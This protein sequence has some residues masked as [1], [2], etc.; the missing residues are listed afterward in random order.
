MAR[1]EVQGQG[2]FPH[3]ASRRVLDKNAA[4]SWKSDRRIRP[5]RPPNEPQLSCPECGNTRLYRD[6][7][8]YCSS[9]ADIQRWLC[10]SCNYRFSQHSEKRP[11]RKKQYGYINNACPSISDR[12]VC[13]LLTEESKNL[14][15]SGTRQ[16]KSVGATAVINVKTEFAEQLKRDGY[17]LDTIRQCSYYL[18]LF[19]KK[20]VNILHPEQVKA[21]VAEQK[22]QTH[23]KATA[24]TIYGIFAKYMHLQW[25]PPRYRYDQKIPF[26]P[27]EKEINDLIAGTG[28]KTSMLLRLLK[29]TGARLTEALRIKWTDVDLVKGTVTINNPEKNSL[30]RMLKISPPL[31]CMLNALPRESDYI[32]NQSRNT[33]GTNYQLQRNRLAKKLQNPRLKQIRLHTFRHFFA[34]MLYAKTMSILRVQQA[35]GHKNLTSTQ[36]YTHLVNFD[37]DEYDVQVAE[38]LEEAKKLGEAGYDYFVEMDGRKLFRKR[39]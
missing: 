23:S 12:Q 38:T 29:E 24:V 14:A 37:S 25:A 28:K 20:G 5:H 33:A 30:P 31:I 7:H 15:I 1:A 18:N 8:R 9:G 21:F 36:L 27:T 2:G 22:W 10:K 6:G 13:D 19:E 16:E 32:L 26:I 11:L 3:R 17:S 39:K 34:T 35:L 4:L